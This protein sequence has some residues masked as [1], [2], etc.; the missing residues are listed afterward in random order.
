MYQRIEARWHA[1]PSAEW[2]PTWEYGQF[3][4]VRDIADAVRRALEVPLE[5]HHRVLLCAADIAAT[6][7]SLV[8]AGRYASSVPVRDTARF[9]RDPRRSLCDHS[10]AARLLGWEPRHQWSTR[11]PYRVG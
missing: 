6:E 9:Q 8:M 3:V 1:D 10:A 2:T 7:A 11:G 4:D 5:G